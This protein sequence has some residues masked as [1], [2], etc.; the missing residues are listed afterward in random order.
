MN[1][2]ALKAA[3]LHL[4]ASII[5]ISIAVGCLIFW[6]FPY[7]F[8]AVDDISGALKIIASVDICL[9]PLL[10]LLLYKPGKKGLW[11]DL[12]CIAIFQLSALSFG[13][14]AIYDSRPA[15]LIFYGDSFYLANHKQIDQSQLT[16]ESLRVGKLGRPQVVA[17]V[18]QGTSS[19]RIA[20]A[21]ASI[22]EGVP[23]HFNAQFFQT[24]SSIE[25]EQLKLLALKPSGIASIPLGYKNDQ[26]YAAYH[27][28]SSKKDLVAVVDIADKK[29]VYI[30]VGS[31]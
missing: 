6:F 19:D 8:L 1:K 22:G 28:V 4:V 21:M 27:I 29:I 2:I 31:Q 11:F 23:V 13:T 3:A 16:D 17:T 18:I 9:G 14:W 7:P 15:Y 5:I 24:F 10:T 30:G 26:Q 20:L 25:S 12:V